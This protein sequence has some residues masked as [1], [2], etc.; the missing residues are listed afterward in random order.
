M[1][2]DARL[3]GGISV[4]DRSEDRA[5]PCAFSLLQL[6]LCLTGGSLK[7]QE[8]CSAQVPRSQSS[9]SSSTLS[10]HPTLPAAA[11]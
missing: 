2:G 3:F 9:S 8:T 1:A 10:L 4:M 6:W 5:A 11:S 7:V